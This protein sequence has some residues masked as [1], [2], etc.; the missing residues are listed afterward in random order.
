MT[1]VSVSKSELKKLVK[2]KKLVETT[3][4]L[5]QSPVEEWQLDKLMKIEK[6]LVN[7]ISKY[8]Y[9]HTIAKPF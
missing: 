8:N 1:E 6:E 5:Q 4:L 2:I 7:T 9:K 3:Y